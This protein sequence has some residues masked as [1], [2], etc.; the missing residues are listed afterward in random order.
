MFE[1]QGRASE[2]TSE[3]PMN[4]KGWAP[5][6]TVCVGAYARLAAQHVADVDVP[7]V[8]CLLLEN[9]WSIKVR[10]S[11]RWRNAM[12][13]GG[14]RRIF[15]FAVAKLLALSLLLSGCASGPSQ[16]TSAA[17]TDSWGRCD[18]SRMVNF[19]FLCRQ[20]TT[21]PVSDLAR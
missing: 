3:S 5:N 1:L 13:L 6:L 11:D 16:P 18:R 10:A 7:F 17:A 8:A 19:M 21:E 15:C 14:R 12:K 4:L 20:T 9:G 2:D